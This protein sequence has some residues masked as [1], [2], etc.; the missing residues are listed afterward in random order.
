MKLSLIAE[1][2]SDQR[3]AGQLDDEGKSYFL[4]HICQVVE[5]IKQVTDDE[6]IIAAAYLHD[7][8]EDT[9][10]TYEELKSIFGERVARLVHEVTHDGQKDNHGYYFPRLQSKEGIMLKFADRLSNIS[11]MT[12]WAI[13]RQENY[14]K[15]SKF[16]KSE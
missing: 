3:H 16:W 14:L 12:A 2:F 8:L 5:I 10:T 7:T 1:V 15:K 11:R 4:A 6:E 13:P 9:K